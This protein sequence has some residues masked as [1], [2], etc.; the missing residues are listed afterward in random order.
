[1]AKTSNLSWMSKYYIIIHFLK[2]LQKNFE[3]FHCKR[4]NIYLIP[5]VD[6]G[7]V[8]RAQLAKSTPLTSTLEP[9]GF[10]QIFQDLFRCYRKSGVRKAT[11]S[12]PIYSSL[13]K[14]QPWFLSWRWK[15]CFGQNCSLGAWVSSERPALGQNTDDDDDAWTFWNLRVHKVSFPGAAYKKK[16]FNGKIY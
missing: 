4:L 12:Y 9:V 1:M 16:Q 5:L 10:L 3:S 8:R 6:F 11:G 13:V 15:T 7:E 14:L 2:R